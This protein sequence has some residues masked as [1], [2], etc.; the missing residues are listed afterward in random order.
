MRKGNTLATKVFARDSIVSLVI[1]LNIR[2]SG[3]QRRVFCRVVQ[4]TASGYQ[5][6]TKYGL[7]NYR[8]PHSELNGV[9]EDNGEIPHLTVQEAKKAK[10]ITL[11]MV[12]SQ[13]NSRDPIWATQRAGRK[14]R[15]GQREH[16]EEDT[17]EVEVDRPI[18]HQRIE[19]AKG[20]SPS[21]RRVQTRA[22]ARRGQ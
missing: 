14:R 1:P 15:Q 17:I 18:R 16:L 19:V 11:N 2:L 21:T 8:Y 12:V 3:E 9:D 6:N 7:L 10:K 13:M 5:L 4:H 20:S 22:R